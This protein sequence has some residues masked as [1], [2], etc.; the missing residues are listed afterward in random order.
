MSDYDV[1]CGNVNDRSVRAIAVKAPRLW[2]AAMDRS[3][4]PSKRGDRVANV[5][6]HAPCTARWSASS[7]SADFLTSIAA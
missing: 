3:A 6:L 1:L 2:R 4:R 7:E 5:D